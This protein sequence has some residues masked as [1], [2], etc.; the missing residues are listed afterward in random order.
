MGKFISDKLIEQLHDN[1]QGLIVIVLDGDAY[2][3]AKILYR[4]LSFGD[5]MGR[6]RICVPPEDYDPSK[7]FEKLGNKGI[8]KLLKSAYKLG[9]MDFY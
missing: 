5:L 2:E 6:V 7:I 1:A 3:D 4:K 9:P 8:I